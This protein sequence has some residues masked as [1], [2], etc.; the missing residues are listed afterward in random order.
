MTTTEF[1]KGDR[2]KVTDVLEA[3]IERVHDGGVLVTEFGDW[4]HTG[5]EGISGGWQ[6]TIEKLPDPEPTW[7]NGDIIRHI[8]A[9]VEYHRIEGRWTAPDGIRLGQTVTWSNGYWEVVRKVA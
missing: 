7:V 5:P 9:N 6:R 3:T 2:V 8:D 4:V 1:K